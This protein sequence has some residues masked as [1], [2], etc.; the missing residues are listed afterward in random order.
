MKAIRDMK[1]PENEA[2]LEMIL[3][4]VNYLGRFSPNL[5]E[6]TLSSNGT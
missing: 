5:A 1:P 6:V 2:E 4:M 3:G